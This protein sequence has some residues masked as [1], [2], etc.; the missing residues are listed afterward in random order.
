MQIKLTTFKTLDVLK[1]QTLMTKTKREKKKGCNTL[2]SKI[3]AVVSLCISTHDSHKI[4]KKG[5]PHSL[6][7]CYLRQNFHDFRISH[8]YFIYKCLKRQNGNLH[9]TEN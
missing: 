4:S 1:Q 8:M 2:R 7:S 6:D 9:Q 5:F 3:K